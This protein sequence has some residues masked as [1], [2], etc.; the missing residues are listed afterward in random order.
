MKIR[1][2]VLAALMIATI[3]VL[4][5]VPPI[6]LGVIP[7]PVVMQNLG[8][9][10]AGTVLGSK[11][12]TIAVG[13]FLLLAFLGFPVLSGSQA[14]PAVFIGPMAGYLLG[15]LITPLIMN[16]TLSRRFMSRTGGQMIAIWVSGVLVVNLIGALWLWV[17]TPISLI[18][19]LTSG[20]LF[21]PGDTV[22][23]VAVYL[24]AIRMRMF[25]GA[26]SGR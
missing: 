2:V 10:L 26:I 3:I 12:G 9:M 23:A 16:Y 13:G 19:A 20:M 7:V 17:A 22:K 4:G 1:E 24:V 14:G 6:P 25:S 5:M 8:I 18:G 11:N 15:W 21:L